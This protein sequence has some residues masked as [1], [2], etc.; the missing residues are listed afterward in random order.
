[1]KSISS[2]IL[3]RILITSAIGMSII[4]LTGS[5]IGGSSI[6]QQA[7]GRIKSQT[8]HSA[9]QINTWLM[10]QVYYVNAV[11]A[12]YS[13]T[14]EMTPDEILDFMIN[15]E[16][17]V[18][19]FYCIYI[20]YPDGTGIFSDEWEPDYSEWQAYERDWYKPAAAAPNNAVITDI[21]MD[22]TTNE[23][24]ISISRAIMNEGKIAAVVAAD[25]FIS[26]VAKIVSESNIGSGS[27][28]FL[29][30]A[31]G[32]IIVHHN[33]AYMPYLDADEETIFQN[34]YEVDNGLFKN[35]RNIGD[36]TVTIRGEYY[37]ANRVTNDW[38]LYT[39]IPARIVNAPIYI[40]VGV[41]VLIFALMFGL[42]F[43]L[44]SAAIKDMII[45]PINDVTEAA[46]NL[47]AGAHVKTL[48]GNYY[49]EIALLADSFH[50]MEQFNN[51]QTDYLERISGGDFSFKVEPRGA[52]DRP[53]IAIAKMLNQLNSVFTEVHN[54]SVT[55]ASTAHRISVGSQELSQG[56]NDLAAA[57]TEQ[58]VAVKDLS[59]FVTEVRGKVE[60]NAVRSQKSAHSVSESGV[61]L[62]KST[63]SMNRL[64]DSMDAINKSSQS[65]QNVI[66]SI[67]DIASQTNLL[68]LNAAIEAARAGEAG[69]GFAV[70]AEE[71]S[72]LAAMSAEAAHETAQ[73]I[74]NSTVQVNNGIEIMG[75]TRQ[76]L[77]A[78]SEKADEIMI[79]SQEI[80]ESLKHQEAT[81]SEVD[82]AVE[83][84]SAS[85]HANAE[86]AEETA[87]VSHESASASEE[88]SAQATTLNRVFETMKL[89]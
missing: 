69:R 40:M 65:I 12:S 46:N 89:K 16:N 84:I 36:K 13:K 15:H 88:M 79:I 38:I 74:H 45:N 72:K 85:I 3:S 70:V 71:V 57:S 80:S 49:G 35:L 8:A 10:E 1:M 56:S 62:A 7:Q 4:T 30:D 86:L 6:H 37:T 43:A 81:V 19:D 23:F 83:K 33:N 76:N 66:Q 78:V 54:T 27:G 28:A 77:E 48:K 20:G 61:L 68:A 52:E 82:A 5:I 41:A 21:Y 24:I 39:F 64:M 26:T 18:A 87:A 73:L 59:A 60:E 47:A 29:T 51:Q 2:R 63:E 31:N 25:V 58:T 14:P 17:N 42:T 32:N 55:I 9:E 44:N 11:A 34:I 50:S 67:D 22:A 75:E 53:G